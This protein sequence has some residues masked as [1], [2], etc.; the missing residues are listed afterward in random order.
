MHCFFLRVEYT[1]S[2]GRSRKCL[3]KDLPQMKLNDQQ[4]TIVDDKDKN[5]RSKSPSPDLLSED[6]RRERE[7]VRWEREAYRE[8]MGDEY[9]GEEEREEDD[10]KRSTQPT[11]YQSVKQDGK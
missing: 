10:Q 6:M 9:E 1:D 5:D 8:A 7:R 2:L 11:H 4:M 3:R